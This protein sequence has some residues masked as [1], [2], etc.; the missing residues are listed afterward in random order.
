VVVCAIR[1]KAQLNSINQNA[2]VI[3]TEV[4]ITIADAG[5]WVSILLNPTIAGTFTD[6]STLSVVEESF[7]G[8]AGT[9]PTIS[10]N[11]TI[12]DRFYV[13]TS[14]NNRNQKSTG[15]GGKVVIAYS[16]LLGAGDVM[17]VLVQG[18]AATDAFATLK[19]KEIR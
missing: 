14:N 2:V 12:I 16:H 4:E 15:L 11:G 3:P 7:A 5:A 19:W 13:G 17:A 8:N 6:V 1:C 10:A 9:D 18:A